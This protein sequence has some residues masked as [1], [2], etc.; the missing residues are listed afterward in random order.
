MVEDIFYT[1]VE[2]DSVKTIVD[3]HVTNDIPVEE[4]FYKSPIT[5]ECIAKYEDIPF[6]NKQNRIILANCGKINPEKIEDYKARDG[7][8]GIEKALKMKQEE[9]IKEIQLSGLRG[10]GGAGFPTGVKWDFA[11]KAQG[12]PKYVIINADEGDPGAF[13]D[14]A[15][16]EADP[17]SVLEG[18]IIGGYAIGASE[19]LIYVRAEYP[20]A[21]IRFSKAIEDARAN[22][23][24]GTNILGSDFSFEIKI[25]K[26]AGAFVCG[27]ETALIKSVEG[28]RGNPVA[29]PPYPATNGLWGKPTNINNVK[30]WSAVA[31]I[32][33]N[34]WENFKK[35]GPE[36]SS[37]TALFSLA[38]KV[39]N[40][41]LIEVPMGTTLNKI[42]YD[43]GGGIQGNK[44]FKAVQTGG[45]SGGCI[46]EY[47]LETPVEYESMAKVG[48]IMGSGGMIVIDEDTCIVDFAKFFLRFTQDES[49]GKCTPCREGT[50]RALKIL[51][52]ITHGQAQLSDL[53]ELE[54]LCKVIKDTSLCGLGM[55]APNPVLSTLK[56]F[57]DDYLEHIQE[58]RCRAGVCPGLFKLHVIQDACDK[59]GVCQKNCAYDAIRGNKEEGFVIIDEYCTGCKN[60]VSVCP[61]ESIE[62]VEWK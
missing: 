29:K 41:G 52:K 56:Y 4:F 17:H 22:G 20:L 42:I 45:P 9:V 46:P 16:L 31:W 37:G 21:I 55:T 19:G 10:R 61:A 54:I 59:C 28:N 26:G 48:S 51:D 30:T 3:S 2:E 40:T 58:N 1:K 49:C 14:G 23:Y 53:D 39:N 35:I 50:L 57:R 33:R 47:L 44:K 32:M 6:Y 5:N 8:R 43:I 24:L 12:E 62:I 36:S 13:M 18:L 27:E 60:C 7:Y 34:G 11:R 25:Y 15:L 38:G